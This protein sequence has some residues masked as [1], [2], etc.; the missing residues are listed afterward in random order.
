MLQRQVLE[1]EAE[2]KFLR[3]KLSELQMIDEETKLLSD[4]LVEL[5]LQARNAMWITRRREMALRRI[6]RQY[7]RQNGNMSTADGTVVKCNESAE[8]DYDVVG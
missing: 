6:K 5:H 8:E 2:N 1:L 7:E 3:D 4:K